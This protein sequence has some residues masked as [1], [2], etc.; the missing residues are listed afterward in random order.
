MPGTRER[1]LDTAERLFAACGFAGTSVREIT[2]AAETNLGAVNYHF[3]SKEN[4]YVEVF[5]RRAGLL[6]E[7]VTAA[8]RAAADLARTSPD[9]ALRTVGRAFL[10]PHEDHDAAQCLLG[11]IAR[12]AIEAR[13]PPGLLVREFL[14]PTIEAFTSIV[15]QARP[16]L[17]ETTAQACAHSFYAQLVHIVKGTG[18]AMASEDEQLEHAVRFTV[19]ALRHLEGPP[20]ERSRGTTQRPPSSWRK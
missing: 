10:A 9:Q 4:L 20:P 1:L 7:P 15:R 17:P 13:L 16:A 12:E 2:D 14:V 8:A 18:G 11:L 3:R 5:A 6:R 19:A